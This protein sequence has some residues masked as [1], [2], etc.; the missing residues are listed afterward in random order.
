M[1]R[2][3]NEEKM[4]LLRTVG[5]K[6]ALPNVLEKVTLARIFPGQL[7]RGLIKSIRIAVGI[8]VNLECL[9]HFSIIS[10]KDIGRVE[11]RISNGGC[12][13]LGDF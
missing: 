4:S 3:G 11:N 6:P 5:A 1:A 7:P 10:I 9:L 2:D 12:C 8:N 13:S